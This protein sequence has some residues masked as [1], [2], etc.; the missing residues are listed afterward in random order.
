MPPSSARMIHD[1]PKQNQAPYYGFQPLVYQKWF[2]EAIAQ[3]EES[4]RRKRLT[5]CTRRILEPVQQIITS[6][7]HKTHCRRGKPLFRFASE[8]NPPTYAFLGIRTDKL[9]IRSSGGGLLSFQ[10]RNA[11][12]KG[13][14][15]V[16]YYCVLRRPLHR[17][18]GIPLH[19]LSQAHRHKWV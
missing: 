1:T 10:V 2:S 8:T 5:G 3:L 4:P 6:T 13:G 18:E 19:P 9:D 15:F 11:V 7:G 14:F 12:D 17:A 16:L